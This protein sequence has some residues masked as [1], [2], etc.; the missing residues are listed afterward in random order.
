MLDCKCGSSYRVEKSNPHAILGGSLGGPV[1]LFC[2]YCSD[3]KYVPYAEFKEYLDNFR[4]DLQTRLM[5]VDEAKAQEKIACVG[6]PATLERFSK[7][8]ASDALMIDVIK[9]E[10]QK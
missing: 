3:S 8:Y 7:D 6:T 10:M 5:T 9:S 4:K 2:E 1:K